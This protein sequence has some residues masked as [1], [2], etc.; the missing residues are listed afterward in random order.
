MP[1]DR[2]KIE[3]EA[4]QRCIN[5]MHAQKS[6]EL[7]GDMQEVAEYINALA[8]L[9]DHIIYAQDLIMQQKGEHD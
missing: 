2:I 9:H 4:M 6:I 3:L 7:S 1:I 5:I 8:H